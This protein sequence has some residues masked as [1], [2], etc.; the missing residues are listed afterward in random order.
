MHAANTHKHVYTCHTYYCAVWSSPFSLQILELIL[1]EP[2]SIRTFWRASKVNLNSWGYSML[3]RRLPWWY[4]PALPWLDLSGTSEVKSHHIQWQRCQASPTISKVTS[5][6]GETEQI[7]TY[8]VFFY[9]VLNTLSQVDDEKFGIFGHTSFWHQ[10]CEQ[11]KRVTMQC[12][13]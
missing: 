9:Q 1:L 11:W 7:W 3:R 8:C 4:S 5:H 6:H 2:S 13:G 12:G 10:H